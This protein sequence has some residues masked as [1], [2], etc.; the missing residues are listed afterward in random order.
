M[1]VYS[2][3]E[4][5]ANL[6]RVLDE[7]KTEHVIIRR[8]TGDSFT[9]TPQSTKTRSPFDVPGLRGT[10]VSRDEILAAVDESRKS[11]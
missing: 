5:R 3:S 8:R 7:A 9:I 11:R 2:F 10:K 1:K 6:A 4:A